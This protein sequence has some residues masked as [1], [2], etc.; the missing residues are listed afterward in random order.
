L[1]ST[2]GTAVSTPARYAH[3]HRLVFAGATDTGR[4]RPRNEDRYGV[5]PDVSL[6]IVADGMG[7]AAAGEVAARMAVDLVCQAFVGAEAPAMMKSGSG[8]PLLVAAIE[9]A[10]ARVHE[11]AERARAWRGMGTTIACV[12]ARG[13]RAALAHVGDSRIYRMRDR[14]LALLTEDHSLFMEFVRHGLADPEHPE[15]FEHRNVIT[16]AVGAGPS[17]EVDARLVEVAPGD[18]FLLCTDGLCG[19]VAH[20]ELATIL[21]EHTNPD[22]AVETLI[23][24]ANDRGGPDNITAVV[25]RW[26]AAGAPSHSARG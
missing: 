19:V 3:P 26:E 5:F 8:L 9:R 25:V 15:R 13:D 7:G 17:V 11:A 12:L 6:F 14:K 2:S 4:E 20:N 16:R 21:L 22:D 23:Q 1:F 10:N 24:R 18:T